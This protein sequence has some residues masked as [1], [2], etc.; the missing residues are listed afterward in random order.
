MYAFLRLLGQAYEIH[1]IPRTFL[2]AE[3]G[4]SP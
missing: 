4:P 3:N 2:S 1:G